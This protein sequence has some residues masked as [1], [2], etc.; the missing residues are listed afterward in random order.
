MA[1]KWKLILAAPETQGEALLIYDKARAGG[2]AATIQP[3]P[4]GGAIR[5]DVLITGLSS[6]MDARVLADKLKSALDIEAQP[7]H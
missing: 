5:Y 6:E 1:A 7:A 3:R 4:Q 2:F